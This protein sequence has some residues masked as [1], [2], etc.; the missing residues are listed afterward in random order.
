LASAVVC[1]LVCSPPLAGSLAI[2]GTGL[3]NAMTA[4]STLAVSAMMA[5]CARHCHCA[6]IACAWSCS[7]RYW[8]WRCRAARC[9]A[10][11]IGMLYPGTY[12]LTAVAACS[13]ANRRSMC[14]FSISRL[15]I[16]AAASSAAALA[17]AA[18]ARSA[19]SSNCKRLISSCRLLT[20]AAASASTF[21]AAAC[22]TASMS[23]VCSAAA[24][25]RGAAASAAAFSAAALLFRIIRIYFQVNKS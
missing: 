5:I 16:V 3:L 25:S 13:A 22:S 4:S 2:G 11:V 23:T 7:V 17:A 1:A 12:T 9:S 6:G 14:F 15:L 10:C 21:M 8:I 18:A 20:V 19:V 24:L